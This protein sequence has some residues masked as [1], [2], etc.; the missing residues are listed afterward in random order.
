[1]PRVRSRSC[2]RGSAPIR[3]ALPW[4]H[5]PHRF[6]EKWMNRERW[7]YLFKTS[8]RKCPLLSLCSLVVKALRVS[9]TQ[10][11]P[12]RSSPSCAR[13]PACCRLPSSKLQVNQ[14]QTSSAPFPHPDKFLVTPGSTHQFP[15][16]PGPWEVSFPA[17]SPAQEP[18][19]L[20]GEPVSSQVGSS[21]ARPPSAALLGGALPG[22]LQPLLSPSEEDLRSGN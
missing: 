8:W 20:A 6:H 1:M 19:L 21:L 7:L 17:H 10:I 12:R 16:K 2:T 11:L 5:C 3:R 22:S 18:T 9:E 13:D 14:M 15:E 4:V